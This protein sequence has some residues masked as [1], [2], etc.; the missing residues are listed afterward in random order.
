MLTIRLEENQK[1][2]HGYQLHIQTP[3]QSWVYDQEELSLTDAGGYV[4]IFLEDYN[5]KFGTAYE[6]H[7]VLRTNHEGLE[8]NRDDFMSRK[9]L[10]DL[11]T[12]EG[13]Y[14]APPAEP[15][16][17]EDESGEVWLSGRGTLI[18]A[19]GSWFD[20]GR[21]DDKGAKFLRGYCRLLAGKGYGG[22]AT[23]IFK[24]LKRMDIK[25]G[26]RWCRDTYD[27]HMNSGEIVSL[28]NGL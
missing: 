19:Y 7:E 5:K 20:E 11:G 9:M 3:V 4:G 21:K 18:F 2:G 13:R 12:G 27:K 8:A 15:E 26:L 24:R 28:L 22:T 16:Y 14:I 25:N 17:K 23:Q 1:Y 10:K 6:P